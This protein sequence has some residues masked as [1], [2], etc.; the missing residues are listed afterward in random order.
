[1]DFS[2]MVFNMYVATED[3]ADADERVMSVAI[4]QALTAASLGFNPWFTEHHFRGAWHSSP[5]Q[6]ASYI[7]A[8]LPEDR[9]L[10]FGVL[11]TPYY[12]PVRL[13]ESMNLLDQLTKGHTLY[14]M[15]S[16]FAGTEPLG[17]GVDA[18]YHAGGKAT[19]ESLEVLQ[20]LW[21][22]RTGDPEYSYA[23]PTH[24]GTIRRR[25]VPAP[26]RK[27]RP[28]IIRTAS[29]DAAVVDAAQHGWPAFLGTFGSESP[30]EDQIRLYRRTLADAKHS[31]ETV[32]DCLRWCTHDWLSVIVADTDAQAQDRAVEAKADALSRR[33]S[34]VKRY[35]PIDGPVISRK[36]GESVAAA[37]AAGGDMLGTIA[38][39]PDTVAK[40]V[41][42]LADLG[43]NHLLVRF[44]G[45]WTSSSRHVAEAS[46]ELFSREVAPRFANTIQHNDLHADLSIAV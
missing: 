19:R 12:N 21:N 28:T 1:M 8:K 30:L 10:G 11:S 22:Y 31:S 36:P 13:L 25:I 2:T 40:K 34:F 6:F 23:L 33:E 44:S 14:G 3:S 5:L 15:G 26:Y 39:S 46:M 20:D 16:G 43:I 41:Q 7:A 17:L 27:D 45:E 29:R 42:H 32:A 18:E 9:Y 24:K 35:G 38:G 37:F 4:E